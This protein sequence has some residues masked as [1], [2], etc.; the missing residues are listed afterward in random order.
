MSYSKN[1]ALVGV[2]L[3]L[4]TAAGGCK[5]GNDA[6]DPI[7]LNQFPQ[8]FAK[9]LCD[10]IAPCCAAAA[11]PYTAANCQ[12]NATDDFTQYATLAS[13]SSH[14][15]YDAD[16][17]GAC[18]SALRDALSSCRYGA[19]TI[20]ACEN[21]FRGTVP[22][23]GACAQSS[24]CAS[25]FCNNSVCTAPTD[26]SQH[27][28]AGQACAGDCYLRADGT[29]SCS[30]LF[31]PSNGN[32]AAPTATGYCYQN[33]GL[34]CDF[35]APTP[36]CAPFKKLGETCAQARC[37]T[38]TFC[39]YQGGVAPVCAAQRDSGPCSTLDTCTEASYCAGGGVALGQC[40]ARKP[41]G[42][43]CTSPEECVTGVC[44]DGGNTGHRTCGRGGISA[45]DCKGNF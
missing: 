3:A 22:A 7:P 27:G 1:W 9:T 43:A 4:G 6:P 39:D 26:T 10:T 32:V 45:D 5:S 30:T 29:A 42:F 33:D 25:Q 23:G 17:A 20:A 40:V 28:Q 13:S 21:M 37:G 41:D 35:S 38:G 14:I 24:E 16:A 15:M 19:G 12:G 11:L 8:T 2:V 18:L 31:P 34:Y 36:A 44:S